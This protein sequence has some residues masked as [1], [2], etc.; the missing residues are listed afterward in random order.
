MMLGDFRGT[1]FLVG[2]VGVAGRSAVVCA[3]VLDKP[4][5][6]RYT[7]GWVWLNVA[8]GRTCGHFYKASCTIAGVL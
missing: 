1:C 4:N 6:V 7:K 3:A 2:G 5:S 8:F